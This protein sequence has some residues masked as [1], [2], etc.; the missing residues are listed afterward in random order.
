MTDA[1]QL[2]PY[3]VLVLHDDVFDVLLVVYV[4]LR[5]FAD[6]PFLFAKEHTREL[7]LN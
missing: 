7:K 1:L 4:V 3:S 5:L 6:E 2:Y